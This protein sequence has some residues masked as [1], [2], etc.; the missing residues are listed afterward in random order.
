M[1]EVAKEPQLGVAERGNQSLIETFPGPA[2]RHQVLGQRGR[3]LPGGRAHLHR[4]PLPRPG[5][6]HERGPLDLHRLRPRLQHLPRLPAT[7]PPTATGPGRTT[8]ST[9]SGCATTGGSPTSRSTG[10][11]CWRR[12]SAGARRP[13]RRPASA[14]VT[15]A[16]ALLSRAGQGR[17]RW[18]CS[19][20][21]PPRWRTRWWPLAVAREGLGLAEVVRGRA[22]RRLAGRASSSGPT[23][24]PTGAGW[25]SP[26]RRSGVA[27][28]AVRRPAGRGG[29][30]QGEGALGG[31]DRAAGGRGGGEAGRP[32]PL[33]VQAVNDGPL[34][35]AAEVLLPAS[36]HAESDGT[37]V[38]FEGRA[39]RFELAYFPRGD[40]RPHWALAGELGRALGV[41]HALRQRA[42]GRSVRSGPGWATAL[43]DFRWD[44]LPSVGRRPGLVPLAAGTVDGR[45]PGYR[46]RVP[47]GDQRGP[48]PRPGAGAARRPAVKRFFGM[49]AAL[50]GLALSAWSVLAP[51]PTCWP[52]AWP[53]CS[54]ASA[55][56][57]RPGPTSAPPSPTCSSLMLVVLMVSAALLTVAERKWS[58]ADPEPD[59]RQPDQGVRQPAGRHPVPARRRAQDAHQGAGRAARPRP[60]PLRARPGPLLRAGVRALRGRAGGAV[61]AHREPPVR[62]RSARSLG[63]LALQ[64]ASPD[65]GLLYVFAIAS[66]AVYGTSLAGWASNNKLALLG[67][68]RASSQMISYEVSLGLSLVGCMIAYRTL[69]LEEMVVAQGQRGARPH[70]GAGH[71]PPAA[72]A[73][74]SSSPAPSPRPSA[75]P[76]TSPRARARSSATSS[77]TRG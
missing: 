27:R 64:V 72:S 45:L 54:A 49:M 37:F 70:P 73:S 7:T 14:A 67:G 55:V 11:G 28:P 2:A 15:R 20:R 34:A 51:A 19:S 18:P 31:G 12:G 77:S 74:W 8:P 16:A 56:E 62:F 26:P 9:R 6:V 32:R 65:V 63:S 1:R 52:A 60:D 24:T 58:A 39:Q 36:P 21:P 59:R 57:R 35:Q 53:G 38:N 61:A 50:V 42:R 30:G 5:L 10:T 68:V 41:E 48:A 71:P 46:E 76:S 17:A 44:S 13:G 40:S 23:R 75:P 3:H 29:L 22:A 47:P 69:R 43:G 33:V 66:L 4:L 25:S